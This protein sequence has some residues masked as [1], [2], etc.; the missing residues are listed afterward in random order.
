MGISRPS[1]KGEGLRIREANT[2][3]PLG[4]TT[5]SKP[6]EERLLFISGPV[7]GDRLFKPVWMSGNVNIASKGVSETEDEATLTQILR[8]ARLASARLCA[9]RNP[10]TSA[11]RGF[12]DSWGSRG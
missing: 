6:F 1:P 8:E 2:R 7:P 9:A 12:S 11:F 4:S 10:E 3:I 5:F